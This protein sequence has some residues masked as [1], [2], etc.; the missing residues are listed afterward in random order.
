MGCDI[1]SIAQR[2]T[3]AGWEDLDFSPFESR[4]YG[5]FGFLADVR[6]YSA[7]PP[8]SPPRGLPDDF[9][10]SE[11][12]WVGDHSF[13]WLSIEELLAFDYDQ[14]VEDRRVTRQEGPNFWNGAH[15]AEPGGGEMTTYRE[16]LGRGF[17]EDLETLKRLKADRVVFGFDS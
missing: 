2:K 1:H 12:R 9:V 4:I 13:S 17:F 11:E 14:P 16:F 8:L 3:D 5:V 7:V 15:T 10:D 6:N